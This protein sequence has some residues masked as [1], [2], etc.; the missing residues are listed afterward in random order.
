MDEFRRTFSKSLGMVF[1]LTLPSSVGLIVLGKSIIGSIYQGGK[2]EVYDTQQTAIA[3]SCYAI[4]LVGYAALK[5]LNP[6][7]YALGDART[8][9]LVSVVSILV[10]YASAVTLI[11]VARLGH[12]GLALATSFVALFAFVVLFVILRTRLGGVYGRELAAGLGRVAVASAAMGA[13][14]YLS[15]GQM[16]RWL[17]LSQMA[18]R[19]DLAVS[20]PLGVAVFYLACRA[21]GVTDLD[22]AFRAVLAPVKRR[23]GR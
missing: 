6:A 21:M 9:M 18:R 19:A 3:L 4:G 22:M 7:F 11:R 14:V 5:V 15:S 2:F 16:E 10:N 1:L 23:L 13:A 17:G 12:A 20:M 8:P